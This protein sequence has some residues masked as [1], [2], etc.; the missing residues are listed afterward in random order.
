[1]LQYPNFLIPSSDHSV[2]GSGRPVDRGSTV[3]FAHA[4]ALVAAH[5]SGVHS[6]A[7]FGLWVVAP[8]MHEWY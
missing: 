1:M 7:G 2:A 4:G 6:V 5:S 3:L 8:Q